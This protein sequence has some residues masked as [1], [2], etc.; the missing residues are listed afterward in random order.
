MDRGWVGLILV[1][2]WEGARGGESVW[3][4]YLGALVSVL[5]MWWM[6]ILWG[7]DVYVLYSEPPDEVRYADVLGYE[8]V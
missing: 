7:W 1:M 4:E 5:G 6:F 3:S 2:M 8:R